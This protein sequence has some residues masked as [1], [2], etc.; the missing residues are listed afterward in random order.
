[1]TRPLMP[2]RRHIYAEKAEQQWTE[3]YIDPSQHSRRKAEMGAKLHQLGLDSAASSARV[4]DLCCGMGEALDTLYEMGFRDLHGVDLTAYPDLVRDPRFNFVQADVCDLPVPD[5]CADIV[6]NIHSLH[7][8]QNSANVDRFLKECHRILKPGGKLL[9]LDFANSLQ[10][11]LAFN[12]LR[13]NPLPITPYLKWFQNLVRSEWYY[14]PSY[15]SQWKLTKDLLHNGRFI[16]ED[17]QQQFF[18]W[19]LRL[20]KPVNN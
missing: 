5:A 18:Y 11:Q 14:L 12:F 17:H 6:I 10:I 1:M 16:V 19:Y 8:L 13:L 3:N 4:F 9:I 7:H 15:L 2:K 20:S